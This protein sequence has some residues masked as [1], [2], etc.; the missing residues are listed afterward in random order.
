MV[1]AAKYEEAKSVSVEQFVF[2]CGN[3]H[4]ASEIVKMETQILM[5]FE[6]DM[7]VRSYV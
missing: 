4:T 5:A 2:L 7:Y 1:L 3:R 6:Y